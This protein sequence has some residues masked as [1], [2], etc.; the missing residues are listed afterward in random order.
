MCLDFR[1]LNIVTIK[2]AYALPIID[3]ILF[4]IG[5]EVKVFTTIDLFS[6]FHQIPMYKDD[7]PKTSFTTMYGNYQFRVMPF[8]LYIAPGT[9]HREM[10]RI[11]L[12]LIG[13][14][15]FV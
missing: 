8:G 4:S 12:P 7:I 14:Y 10:N 6:G 2:D 13:I 1:K 3:E 11:F 5:T 15:M 9:F